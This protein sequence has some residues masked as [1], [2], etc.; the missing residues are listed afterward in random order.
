[1]M[2]RMNDM[3]FNNSRSILEDP[4]VFTGATGATSDSTFSK[5]GFENLL[6]AT[7][8]D[9]IVDTSLNKIS[10]S[11]VGYI[12]SIIFNK[13]GQKLV[14]VNIQDVVYSPKNEFNLFSITKRLKIG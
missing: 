2:M 1:M 5:L 9:T 6:K 8:N 11:V 14:S 10:G 12:P 7:E 4:N 13:H 3:E